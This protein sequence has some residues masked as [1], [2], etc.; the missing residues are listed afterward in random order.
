Q[1]SGSTTSPT[2]IARVT[3]LRCGCSVASSGVI[4]PRSSISWTAE[5]STVTCSSRRPSQL[6]T[7]ESPTLNA[8]QW[9][10]ASDCT[11]ASPASVVPETASSSSSVIATTVWFDWWMVCTTVSGE[12]V[13]SPVR[14]AAKVP[15]TDWL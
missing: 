5:W 6:Y 3:T 4:C 12:K 15:T 1:M 2:P 8:I 11:S 9:Y 14:A 13:L 7:R 10:A